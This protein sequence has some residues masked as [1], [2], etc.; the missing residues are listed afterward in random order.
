MKMRADVLMVFLN[1][2]RGK[3]FT[4]S[5]LKRHTGVPKKFVGRALAGAVC[6]MACGDRKNRYG[7]H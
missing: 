5:E 7:V 2:N 1:A 6:V 4:A 3:A